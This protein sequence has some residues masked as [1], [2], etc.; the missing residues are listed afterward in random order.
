[1]Y[2]VKRAIESSTE[3]GKGELNSKE[4]DHVLGLLADIIMHTNDKIKRQDDE[5]AALR[6]EK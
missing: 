4:Q 2:K 5:V 6:R 1:M 3:E